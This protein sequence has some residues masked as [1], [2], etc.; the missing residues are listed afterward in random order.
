MFVYDSCVRANVDATQCHRLGA[1]SNCITGLLCFIATVEMN[2]NCPGGIYIDLKLKDSSGNVVGMA[3]ERT[4]AM[5]KR[6][7]GLCHHRRRES[8]KGIVCGDQLPLGSNGLAAQKECRRSTRFGQ[9][10]SGNAGLS[11]TPSSR[12]GK[13][14]R[15][16]RRLLAG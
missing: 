2:G 11:P 10:A 6:I 14:R 4:P 16:S 13:L 8:T 3:N 15:R 9:D 7:V 5:N 1:L 12:F